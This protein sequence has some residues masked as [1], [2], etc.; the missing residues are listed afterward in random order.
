MCSFI[1]AFVI[2]GFVHWLRQNTHRLEA[3]IFFFTKRL[4][5]VFHS[6]EFLYCIGDFPLIHSTW[7]FSKVIKLCAFVRSCL[8]MVDCV[9]SPEGVFSLVYTQISIATYRAFYSYI[10]RPF[11]VP[12]L[13]PRTYHEYPSA[14]PK[15]ENSTY[16]VRRL[17]ALCYPHPPLYKPARKGQARPSLAACVLCTVVCV[18]TSLLI[19]LLVFGKLS[20]QVHVTLNILRISLFSL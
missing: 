8:S 1:L 12:H 9:I 4:D 3:V 13:Q 17:E 18:P 5:K 15:R 19:C 14:I 6:V 20:L 2:F 16:A 10:A 11:R 7:C